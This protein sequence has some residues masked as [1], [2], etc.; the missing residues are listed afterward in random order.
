MQYLFKKGNV[1]LHV[2]TATLTGPHSV[3]VTGEKETT[4]LSASHI[5]VAT[6]LDPG[7][8]LEWSRMAPT[9]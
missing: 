8:F 7:G 4:E 5:I 2:G 9:S 6:G 1:D 3:E